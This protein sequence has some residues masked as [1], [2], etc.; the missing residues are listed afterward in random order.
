MINLNDIVAQLIAKLPFLTDRVSNKVLEVASLTATSGVIDIVFGK[1]HNLLP[2]QYVTLTDTYSKQSITALTQSGTTITVTTAT[3]HDFSENFNMSAV[4]SGANESSLNGTFLIKKVLSARQFTCISG[5]SQTATG[6]GTIV[7]RNYSKNYDGWYPV[8]IV[9]DVTI[10][11]TKSGA[12][13]STITGGKVKTNHLLSGTARPVGENGELLAELNVNVPPD[14]VSVLVAPSVTT[15]SRDKSVLTDTTNLQERGS[16]EKRV[17]FIHQFTVWC[18]TNLV[19]DDIKARHALYTPQYEVLRQ[20]VPNVY[21]AIAAYRPASDFS[22][23]VTG[24]S[25]LT[26]NLIQISGKLGVQIELGYT[27]DMAWQDFFINNRDV[28]ARR[29]NIDLLSIN[30]DITAEG[31][32]P[33]Q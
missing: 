13:D 15:T 10:R 28:A 16:A 17:R 23:G 7:T 26:E 22:G 31:S 32:I 18:L 21:K 27:E 12:V 3:D 1:H 24:I 30:P 5:V 9:D 25:P 20:F 4:I 6:T 19:D 2:N 29:F 33:D 14:K 8:T 11:V